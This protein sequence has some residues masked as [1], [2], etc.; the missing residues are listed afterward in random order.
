MRTALWQAV[1]KARPGL[2]DKQI[3]ALLL[4]TARRE[5]ALV[6]DGLTLAQ[7]QELVREELFPPD[8][9]PWAG[10]EDYGPLR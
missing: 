2:T 8:L 4:D 7:A 9:D 3:D 1:R 10:D 5:R 6:L